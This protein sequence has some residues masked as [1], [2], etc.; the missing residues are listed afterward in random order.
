MGRKPTRTVTPEARPRC[1]RRKRA[2]RIGAD[3]VQFGAEQR[4]G[5]G[6]AG[7]A[8]RHEQS[9]QND[10]DAADA[11]RNRR[12]Q[13]RCAAYRGSHRQ[14]LRRCRA[15]RP[16]TANCSG[17]TIGSSRAAMA[18]RSAA[19]GFLARQL[20]SRQR[21]RCGRRASTVRERAI[22]RPRGRS[23]TAPSVARDAAGVRRPVDNPN[24][25]TDGADRL[26][27]YRPFGTA[28]PVRRA[29][30]SHAS[31][32]VSQRRRRRRSSIRPA[33]TGPMAPVNSQIAEEQADHVGE[34]VRRVS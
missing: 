5:G 3:H 8:G 6:N 1:P 2:R 20:Q 11:R 9:E 34:A 22:P 31:G 33:A 14:N 13:A 15:S 23:G 17:A 7:A 26:M 32:C 21:R 12:D 24:A 25:E 18:E 16:P 30:R 28:P 19:I 27:S 29:R 4:D 10:D